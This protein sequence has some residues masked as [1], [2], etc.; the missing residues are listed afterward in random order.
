[1]MDTPQDILARWARLGIAWN[2]P[3]SRRS[4]DVELLIAQSMDMV[5]ENP[6]LLVLVASWLSVYWRCVGRDRLRSLASACPAR[7]QATLGLLLETVDDWLATPVFPGLCARLARLSPPEPL[8]RSDCD[9]PALRHLIELEA[10]LLSRRWG[11]LCL[12]I[13]QKLDAIRPVSWVLKQNPVLRTRSLFKG[14]LK[15][16]L[17]ASLGPHGSASSMTQLARECGVTRKAVYD[18][19][20][21]LTFAGLTAQPRL[22]GP[23]TSGATTTR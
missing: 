8:F 19:M 15:T 20:E 3:P 18:A 1:M 12:P 9:R 21:D 6:R 23:T 4:P 16:S 14:A 13:E 7:Q 10:T 5:P 17:L 11:L 22:T 2:V